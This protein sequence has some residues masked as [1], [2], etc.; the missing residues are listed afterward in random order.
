MVNKIDSNFTGLRYTPEVVGQPGVLPTILTPNW[1]ELEPNSYSDTGATNTLTPRTPINASR[2]RRK[3]RITDRES[4]IGF[5]L[6]FTGDNLVPFMEGYFFSTWERGASKQVL[7][8]GA[9]V[10]ATGTYPK[11]AAFTGFLVRHIVQAKGF[12]VPANNG[13][14]SVTAATANSI[15]VVGLADEANPPDDAQVKIVG[16]EFAAGIATINVANPLLP[17]LGTGAFD[18]TTLGLIPGQWIWIGGDLATDTFAG[19]GNRGAARV[20]SVTAAAITFDKTQ[21]VMA[22]DLGTGISLKVYFGDVCRN[23]E[24]P[25]NII[26]RSYQFERSLASAGYEYL[27]GSFP[28]ELT[29]N[30]P[31]ADKITLD[32]SFISLDAEPVTARKAG[33]FPAIK[34][35]D[36]AFNTSSDLRLRVSEQGNAAPLFAYLSELNCTVNNNIEVLK[37]LGVLGGFDVSIGDFEV[38]GDATAYFNDLAAVQ[39][40]NRSANL[41]LDFTLAFDNQGWVFDIPLFAAEDGQLQ[42]E[43]DSAINISLGVQAARDPTYGITF[44]ACYFPYLPN[45]AN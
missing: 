30:M 1:L 14:K 2:Q 26:T 16:Y 11:T 3:G 18:A 33:N 21:N 10:A 7:D 22:T 37:A 15:A 40:V 29:L 23:Q 44:L 36:E 31:T 39:A 25:A 45:A 32:M 8:L 34:T 13:I 12:A 9:I 27:K 20:R 41:T 28:N 6:D 38:S 17:V 42:V 5:E 19:V 4:Q 35:K 24:N 43:K